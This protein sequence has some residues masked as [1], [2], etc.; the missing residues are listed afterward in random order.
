MASGECENCGRFEVFRGKCRH[1]G[2]ETL[3]DKVETE[4]GR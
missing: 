2:H 1:C 4:G 3:D